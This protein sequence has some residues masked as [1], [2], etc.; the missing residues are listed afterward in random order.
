MNTPAPEPELTSAADESASPLRDVPPS[1][2]VSAAP[3]RWSGESFGQM[4]SAF[5]LAATVPLLVGMAVYGLG[6]LRVV[7]LCAAAAFLAEAVMNRAVNRPS[8]AS[9]A[10]AVLTGLLLALTLPPDV[11]WRVGLLGSVAAIVLGKWILG[12]LGHYLWHPALVGRAVVQL[13]YADELTPDRWPLLGAG[14]LFGGS[15]A[16][17][18]EPELY[19]GWRHTAMPLGQEAWLLRRPVD[20]LAELGRADESELAQQPEALTA[21]LRD[22]LPPWEDTLM[23][24]TVG[25]IGEGGTIF[26]VITGL[27]LIYRGFVR[28]QLPVGVLIAA[29]VAAAILPVQ[30]AGA[31]EP[32]LRWLPVTIV[33]NGIPVGFVYVLYHLSAGG[34][35]LGAFLFVTDIVASPLT[36]RGQLVF[37]LGIGVMT[38]ILRLYAGTT[39]SAY[40][41]ILIMNT[42]VPIIDQRTKRRVY[43]T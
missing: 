34:L 20:M 16:H 10:H 7:F 25:G 12:G 15:L 8:P 39:G 35:M 14:R 22:H 30:Q 5:L 23:G 11:S 29:A 41:A 1:V 3:Y 37:G 32:A 21:L 43:G 27:F 13:F 40:W 28:W 42:F 26:L 2:R 36:T 24:T 17:A 4:T 33:E 19:V 38:I 9:G 18:T 31:G 6:V